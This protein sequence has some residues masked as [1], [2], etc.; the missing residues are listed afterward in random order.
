MRCQEFLKRIRC[1][2]A[3]C[4][5]QIIAENSQLDGKPPEN[6]Q[7]RATKE[8]I[9]SPQNPS[10]LCWNIQAASRSRKPL[11]NDQ[12]RTTKENIL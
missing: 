9:L 6:D 12:G 7:R 3:C 4:N 10:F 8:T 1:L 2:L 5:S 11:D